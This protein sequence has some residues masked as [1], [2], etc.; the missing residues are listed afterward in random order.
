V[1]RFLRHSEIVVVVVV[2]VVVAIA[3]ALEFV[4]EWCILFK[5]IH[6]QTLMLLLLGLVIERSR[7]RL[8]NGALPGS[9]G[10]LNLL[11]LWGM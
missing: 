3:A 7:V 2:A 4:G 11:S 10:Q 9:L 1:P 5:T 8:P 6:P